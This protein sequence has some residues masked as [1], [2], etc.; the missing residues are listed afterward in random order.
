MSKAKFDDLFELVNEMSIGA[1]D[2]FRTIDNIENKTIKEIVSQKSTTAIAAGITSALLMTAGGT[3]AGSL[4]G[5]IG[6]GVPAAASFAG[7]SG[8][9]GAVAGNIV[10]IIGPIIFG[11]IGAALGA[12][13][14]KRKQKKHEAKKERLKQEVISKQNTIIRDMESE[15]AELVKKYEEAV[16]QNKRYKYLVGILMA[17][18]E[19]KKGVG[20]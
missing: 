16:E 7:V 17:N 10:P 1:R 14:G 8:V 18:E 19:L 4:A 2:K 9:I 11:A 20:I 13:L 15:L 6:L 3:V 5:G 12:F